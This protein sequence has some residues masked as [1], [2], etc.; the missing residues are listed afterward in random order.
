MNMVKQTLFSFL[1]QTKHNLYT[2][3]ENKSRNFNKV[4]IEN[5]KHV[6]ITMEKVRNAKYLRK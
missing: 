2:L 5:T 4:L 6:R 1:P 3:C